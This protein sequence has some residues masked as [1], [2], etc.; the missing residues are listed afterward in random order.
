MKTIYYEPA[1]RVHS[2]QYELI[3][4]PPGGYKFVTKKPGP[5]VRSNFVFDKVRLQVLDRLMP[6]NLTKARLDS[7]LSMP[8]ADMI[9]AYNHVVF[10]KVPWVVLVEWANILVGRDL[11]FF[12]KYRNKIV[13]ALSS[14]YCR[15]IIVW[16]EMAKESIL[17][18]YDAE[19]FEDKIYTIP[20]AIKSTGYARNYNRGSVNLLF[21]GSSNTPEDF[22]AKGAVDVIEAFKILKARHKNLRL[23]IRAKAPKNMQATDGL[24]VIDHIIPREELERLFKEADIFVL[25]SHFAQEMVIVEAMKYGLPIVTSWIGSSCGEYVENNINGLVLPQNGTKYFTD[26]LM[27]ISETIDRHNLIKSAHNDLEPLVKVLEQLI[28]SPELRERLGRSAKVEVD[29]GRFSIRHRNELLKEV[30]ES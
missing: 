22:D 9:F 28:K 29:W 11:R 2:S 15:G 5:L 26:D 4:N 23:V 10:R 27:L 14:E 24:T 13:E 19:G 8:K 16:T 12:P 20:H 25:P 18:N 17:L 30:L 21:V 1:G 7:L 3:N 6:L